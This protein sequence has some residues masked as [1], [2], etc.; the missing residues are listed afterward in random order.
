GQQLFNTVFVPGPMKDTVNAS[1]PENDVTAF[2][3]LIPD[4]LTT[5]DNDGTGNTIAN[6]AGLLDA[7]GVTALP[8]GAPLLR[9]AAFPNTDK[10]LLRKALLPDVLRLDRSRPAAELGIGGNGLQNGRRLGDDVLDIALRL[11][12][13]LADVRFPAGSNLPGSGPATGRAA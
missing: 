9:P 13:Q 11:L 6:R 7:I 12:R 5:S 1:I 3:G 10:G 4:A 2:S 8:N